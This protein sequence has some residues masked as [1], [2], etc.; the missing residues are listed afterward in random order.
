MQ[1]NNVTFAVPVIQF[2][3]TYYFFFNLSYVILMFLFNFHG[4]LKIHHSFNLDN[5]NFIYM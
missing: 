2:T 1:R 5:F 4:Y 3:F